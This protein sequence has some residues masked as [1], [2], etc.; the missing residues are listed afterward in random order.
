ML[1][2][3][4]P[5]S[6]STPL[7]LAREDLA[8]PLRAAANAL[9]VGLLLL[10]GKAGRSGEWHRISMADARRWLLEDRGSNPSLAAVFFGP[11]CRT[12]CACDHARMRNGA[13]SPKHFVVMDIVFRKE[14]KDYFVATKYKG[15]KK[16]GAAP[17]VLSP[18]TVE[19]LKASPGAMGPD[20][21]ARGPLVCA[22]RAG[23]SSAGVAGWCAAGR[24]ATAGGATGGRGG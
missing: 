9:V 1:L 15:W 16:R 10:N 2:P 11:H 14:G 23:G 5:S 3:Q 13:G 19:A 8:P 7:S 20:R 22:G 4:P 18:G 12:D 21:R 17:K 6:H 24:W